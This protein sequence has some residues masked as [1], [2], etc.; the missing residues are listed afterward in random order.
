MT[1]KDACDRRQGVDDLGN[2]EIPT[3]WLRASRSASEL[4]VKTG[5]PDGA[6]TH[7]VPLKRRPGYTF[8]G[9]GAQENRS[10]ASSVAMASCRASIIS[11]MSRLPTTR[12]YSCW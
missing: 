3:R 9:T 8:P 10:F 1:C 12:A 2:F 4:Q 11:P 6:R 7:I 5:V